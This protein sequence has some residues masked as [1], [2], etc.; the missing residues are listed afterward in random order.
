MTLQIN[1]NDEQSYTVLFFIKKLAAWLN[2]TLFQTFEKM[3]LLQILFNFEITFLKRNICINARDTYCSLFL[4][5]QYFHG[6]LIFTRFAKS[7][8]A[9]DKNIKEFTRFGEFR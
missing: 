9:T 6:H 2:Y 1:I 4:S 8:A 3:Y 7:D 5:Q